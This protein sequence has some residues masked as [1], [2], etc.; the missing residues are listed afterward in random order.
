M[1]KLSISIMTLLS[2]FGTSIAN[3]QDAGKP[4]NVNTKRTL[5]VESFTVECVITKHSSVCTETVTSGKDKGKTR[6]FE[7]P[8]S[9]FPIEA[10]LQD[11]DAS[12][13]ELDPLEGI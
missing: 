1:T 8:R 12:V 3:A 4:I 10:E 13:N 6:T 11:W 2:I 7:G 9:V 5:L